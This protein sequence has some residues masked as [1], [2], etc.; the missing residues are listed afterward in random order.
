MTE[1]IENLSDY[2]F[3]F[4]KISTFWV[5]QGDP[6]TFVVDCS[7]DGQGG[8]HWVL[9]WQGKRIGF[10][11]L[12]FMG[13]SNPIEEPEKGKYIWTIGN[14]GSRVF[15]HKERP[16]A[17]AVVYK[18][19]NFAELEQVQNLIVAFLERYSPYNEENTSGL[20]RGQTRF[21][22]DLNRRIKNE[23]LF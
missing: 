6:K 7:S 20:K 4:N 23:E 10:T 3:E 13:R 9:Y 12:D 18:F 16:E 15:G 22:D 8:A 5:K 21:S 14:I 19:S 1:S 2:V 17:S 11:T